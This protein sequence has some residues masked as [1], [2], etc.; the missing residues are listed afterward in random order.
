MVLQGFYLYAVFKTD[1]SPLNSKQRYTTEAICVI[2]VWSLITVAMVAYPFENRT[3]QFVSHNG[4]VN[5]Y[6]YLF[7][8]M[9]EGYSDADFEYA[10]ELETTQTQSARGIHLIPAG[11][12]SLNGTDTLR[13]MAHFDSV[14]SSANDSDGNRF[15]LKESNDLVV[16]HD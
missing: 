6:L 14:E 3:M 16:D 9:F 13:E 15:G 5:L 2:L 11:G 10:T 4:I 12:A 1:A 7:S 8:Y